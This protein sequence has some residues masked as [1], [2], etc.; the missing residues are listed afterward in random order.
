MTQHASRP[1]R[2]GR[3]AVGALTGA[4]ALTALAGCSTDSAETDD[5]LSGT[6]TFGNFMWLEPA[7]GETLWEG[8]TLYSEENSEATIEQWTSAYAS[9][10]DSLFTELGAGGGPDVFLVTT[11]ELARLVEA[12][13]AEPLDDVVSAADGLNTTSDDAILDGTHYGVAWSRVNYTLIYNIELLEEAGVEPPTT[14]D[15]LIEAGQA[16]EAATGAKGFA[17]RHQMNESTP[18][19]DDFTNWTYGYGGSWSDGTSLTIDSP[20]NIEGLTAFVDVYDAGIMPIGDDASTFRSK[21]QSGQVAMLIENGGG[22]LA[23][24]TSGELPGSSIGAVEMPFEH[25][26]T[27][28]QNIL[29]VN[30]NSDNKELAKDFVRWT[31]TPAGQEALRPGLNGG[32]MATDIPDTEEFTDEHSSW[33]LMFHEVAND[34]TSSLVPG[35]E[36]DTPAIKQIIMGYVE[37]A[38]LGELD[39]AEALAQ[40]QAEAEAAYGG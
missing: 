15:E 40:A 28:L 8:T 30:A 22:T 37:L 31:L 21:F 27:H 2:P 9:Y 36:A 26:G 17:V 4:L 12:G 13:I 24:A 14:V 19:S 3:L 38:L 18:W 35:F 23:L 6:I 5:D 11:T 10:F 34:S 20:E 16:I 39:P 25:P 7:R 29:V 33:S 32:A 1:R